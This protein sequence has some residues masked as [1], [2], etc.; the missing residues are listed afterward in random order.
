MSQ[1]SVF[2]NAI[3]LES[4]GQYTE[5]LRLFEFSL[6]NSDHDTGDILFHCGW[7]L[8][9][10]PPVSIHTVIGFYKEA[11]HSSS[12]ALCRM[13][14]FF[15]IGWLLMQ[16]KEYEE[17]DGYFRKSIQLHEAEQVHEGIYHQ[18]LY[19]SAV[20]REFLGYYIQAIKLYQHIQK[21]S[22]LLNPES[23]YRQIKCLLQVGSFTDVLSICES[24]NQPPP[25]GF[26]PLRY[27]QLQKLA[28]LEY[29]SMQN[30]L[31]DQYITQ[32]EL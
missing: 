17:A 6:Q 3:K 22:P 26:D 11:A 15:R 13:N 25:A 2:E 4:N 19:W 9:N 30:C 23:R 27:Q 10:I 24:F 7:C 29:Q 12:I 14:S 1:Y 16:N 31:S 20:C 32:E 5:A 28:E 8:E 18:A 21:I